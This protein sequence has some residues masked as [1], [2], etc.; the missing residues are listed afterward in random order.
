MVLKLHGFNTRFLAHF[1]ALH[2]SLQYMSDSLNAVFVLGCQANI[3]R[4]SQILSAGLQTTIQKPC[5]YNHLIAKSEVPTAL[6]PK[7]AIIRDP[8]PDPS[9][10]HPQTYFTKFHLN[11][12]PPVLFS[13]FQV[14]TFKSFTTQVLYALLVFPIQG[15]ST[16]IAASYSVHPR[17]EYQFLWDK[18]FPLSSRCI[19]SSIIILPFDI[20]AAENYRQIRSEYSSELNAW[21]IVTSL[22][23]Q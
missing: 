9:I 22:T 23:S 6:L 16:V 12:I 11:V 18:L 3:L 2:S 13:V 7:P 14:A 20:Y 8:E 5:S 21:P 19:V 10:S 4:N 17:F 15:L 1:H